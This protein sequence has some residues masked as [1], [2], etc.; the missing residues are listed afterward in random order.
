MSQME[1]GILVISLD[2]ELFW[3]VFDKFRFNT[4]RTNIEGCRSAIP[5]ILEIFQKYEIHSTWAAIGF[6]FSESREEL[7]NN[8]PQTKPDYKNKFYSSYHYLENVGNNEQDDPFHFAP[9]LIKMISIHQNQEI[10]THT[11]SHYYCLEEGQDI[12]TFRADLEAAINIGKKFNNRFQSIVFPRNQ[13]NHYYLA[14][15][16]ENGLKAYRGNEKSWLYAPR[17]DQNE[18][19]IRRALR[20]IDAYI[21]LSGFNTYHIENNDPNDLVNIPASRFL[22]P[23]SKLLKIIE[24]IRLKRIL[25]EMTH[26]AREKKIFHLWWHPHNFGTNTEKN[27]QFLENILSHFA[28]LREKYSM[29]SLNM[30]ELANQVLR[31]Q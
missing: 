20:L 9:S 6:L 17:N 14:V 25:S 29:I 11:F 30:A 4:Y 1:K 10:A 26:A 15:C 19:L 8:L 18:S 2:F 7:N 23:Y 5:K 31:N 22:R 21:N 12:D 27:L 28:D 3:G 13:V 16:K 24:P